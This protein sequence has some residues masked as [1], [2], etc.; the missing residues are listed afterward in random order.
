[1]HVHVNSVRVHVSSP[2]YAAGVGLD[3]TPGEEVWFGL[4]SLREQLVDS[5]DAELREAYGLPLSA[6]VVLLSLLKH[7]GPLAVSALAPTVGLVSR[8][9]VSRLVDVLAARGL[10]ERVR[11]TGDARV[12]AVTITDSGRTVVADGR[13]RAD[14]VVRRLVV[15]RLPATDVRALRRVLGKLAGYPA[16]PAAA[17]GARRDGA[18]GA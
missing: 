5:L 12:H 11:G 16:A 9:Q 10:V 17:S 18:G 15:D 3:T 2:A 6:F 7:P 14:E 13:R 4:L 1:M 8:S